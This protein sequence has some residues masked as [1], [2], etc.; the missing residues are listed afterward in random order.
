[1]KN[2]KMTEETW[3]SVRRLVLHPAPDE[4]KDYA[5]NNKPRDHIFRDVMKVARWL[6]RNPL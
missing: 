4:G 1:M 2:V 3:R 5:E 6:D